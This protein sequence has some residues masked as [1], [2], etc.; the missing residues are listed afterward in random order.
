MTEYR[1]GC[2]VSLIISSS[3]C[4]PVGGA[5]CTLPGGL[6]SIKYSFLCDG[7]RVTGWKSIHDHGYACSVLDMSHLDL[8]EI[9][10]KTWILIPLDLL[11]TWAVSR[12]R[13]LCSTV[14]MCP[15]TFMGSFLRVLD[16]WPNDLNTLHSSSMRLFWRRVASSPTRRWRRHAY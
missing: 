13:T 7:V 12:S 3:P 14:S 5:S 6:V 8:D 10:S 2:S 9:W 15:I 1:I 4:V 16:T 11:T